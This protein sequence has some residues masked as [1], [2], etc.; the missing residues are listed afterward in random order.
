MIFECARLVSVLIQQLEL[1]ESCEMT[2]RLEMS[3]RQLEYLHQLLHMLTV[4][5]KVCSFDPV[6]LSLKNFFN[7]V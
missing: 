2:A 1:P 4:D 7:S 5:S 3:H 6:D